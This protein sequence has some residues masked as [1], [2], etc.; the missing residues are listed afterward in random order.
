[1]SRSITVRILLC[2]MLSSMA[3]A[4]SGQPSRE[5]I[6]VNGRVVATE[7][8]AAIR[9]AIDPLTICLSAGQTRQFTAT[10]T[11]TTNGAVTWS[12]NPSDPADGGTISLN[13]LYTAPT[14]IAGR[15][16]AHVIATAQADTTKSASATV[17]FDCSTASGN[18]PIFGTFLNFYRAFS[19]KLWEKEFQYM[20]DVQ[21]DRVI[22]VAVGHLRTASAGDP[23]SYMG[24]RLAADGLLYPSQ[25]WVSDAERPT[26]TDRL[27]M[28]L[29]LADAKGM[30]VYL[31][32]LQT[33]GDWYGSSAAEFA[34]LRE[35]N[36]RVANEI[37]QLYGTHQ[38]LRGWY[39]TQEIWMNWVKY[40][41]QPNQDYYGTT[42]VKDFTADMRQ[43]NASKS[44]TTSTVLK[45]DANGSMP[46][47]TPQELQAVA[48][49]FL[50]KTQVDVLMPQ[51][52]AGAGAGAPPLNQLPD[53]FS[54]LAAACTAA[55]NRTSLWAITEIF[56]PTPGDLHPVVDVSRIATQ[57]NNVQGYV[58]GLVSWI[59]GDQ[60]SPQATN[61]PVE[62]S[63]LN[64]K[65]K[66]LY[67][68]TQNPNWNVHQLASYQFLC[69]QADPTLATVPCQ[70]SGSYVD[71]QPPS[72]LS[73][74]TG[75]GYP[76]YPLSDWVGFADG[77]TH[78][79]VEITADL[80]ASYQ[81]A[82]VRA[83]T[84]SW[85]DSGIRHPYSMGVSV[86]QDGISWSIPCTPTDLCATSDFPCKTDP[87]DDARCDTRSFA[88][89]WAE[90]QIPGTVTAR[91]VKWRF[92]QTWWFFLSELEVLGPDSAVAPSSMRSLS[93]TK[94]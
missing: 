31:G 80:G 15:H 2:V 90:V 89:W 14:V 46:G 56:G 53:Y 87:P 44:V 48:T 17:S 69:G 30:R 49:G 60:L 86:S 64:R 3:R 51:D 72:K 78:N 10:V 55:G 16:S 38:S 33:T 70:P 23:L 1:M 26:I 19:P 28:I 20:S 6:R 29:S 67:R 74:R 93:R 32:S 25:Q 34:A 7:S 88:V 92:W 41:T 82:S 54:A 21:I 77:D 85:L 81:I 9:I 76:A 8:P 65:Y 47:L 18:F 58:S 36:K 5:Y 91:Y 43:I 22:V 50:Q 52:G 24:Y 4:Q 68:P 37:L 11:G 27:G 73:N 66:F 61:Y 63:A 71:S 57:V 35:Y 83:L 59:F 39:F 13:G 75:G 62:A 84:Q 79:V 45:K 94:R 40:Y 42:L 12:V